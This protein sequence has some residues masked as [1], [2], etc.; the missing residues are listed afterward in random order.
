ML[1][2]LWQMLSFRA[3]AAVAGGASAEDRERTMEGIEPS[4]DDYKYLE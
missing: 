2:L 4:H 1:S 3:W